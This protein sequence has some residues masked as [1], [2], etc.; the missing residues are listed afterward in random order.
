MRGLWSRPTVP[1][2]NELWP[3]IGVNSPILCGIKVG[4]YALIGAGSVVTKDVPDHAFLVSNPGWLTGSICLCG[5]TRN[6]LMAYL[7]EKDIGTE[8]YYPVAFRLQG[9]FQYLEHKEGD[10]AESERAAKETVAIPI[11]PEL[12]AGQQTKVVEAIVAIYA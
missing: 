2:M 1:R 4:E 11:Y 9:C 12:T 5:G 10:F 8:I 7:K 3:T 6:E